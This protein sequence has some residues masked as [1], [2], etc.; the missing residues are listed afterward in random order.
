MRIEYVSTSLA[1]TPL[2]KDLIKRRKVSK[3][4]SSFTFQERSLRLRQPSP[5]LD[6]SN[7]AD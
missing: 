1:Q 2:V 3:D 6:Y 7:R 4:F 5:T